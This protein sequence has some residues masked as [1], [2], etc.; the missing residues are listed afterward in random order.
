MDRYDSG[1]ALGWFT[2][3]GFWVHGSTVL[4]T[5]ETGGQERIQKPNSLIAY[6]LTV[7]LQ[8]LEEHENR[9]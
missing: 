9:T 3:Q 6:S 4:E 8:R 7:Y 1:K 2:V 5:Q